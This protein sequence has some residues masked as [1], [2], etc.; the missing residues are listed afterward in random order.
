MTVLNLYDGA[1]ADRMPIKNWQC[2]PQK[3]ICQ[4]VRL[5]HKISSHM[6]LRSFLETLGRNHRH[7]PSSL[8]TGSLELVRASHGLPLRIA[9]LAPKC[10]LVSTRYVADLAEGL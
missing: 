1:F 8:D 6:S 4:I 9:Y 3:T 2:S 7:S 10:P 5:A